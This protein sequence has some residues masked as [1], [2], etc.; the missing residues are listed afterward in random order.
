MTVDYNIHD[1]RLEITITFSGGK[2][3]AKPYSWRCIRCGDLG[4]EFATG[5]EARTSAEEHNGGPY[6]HQ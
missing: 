6:N 1:A 5:A 3:V 2:R 4:P